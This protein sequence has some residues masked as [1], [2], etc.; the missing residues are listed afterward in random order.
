M[1]QTYIRDPS[2]GRYRY[3]SVL[4]VQFGVWN[5]DKHCLPGEQ[6][7]CKQLVW[8]IMNRSISLTFANSIDQ[9]APLVFAHLIRAHS[10]VITIIRDTRANP[11]ARHMAAN[12]MAFETGIKE[13][14]ASEPKSRRP[15]LCRFSGCILITVKSVA[16]VGRCGRRRRS[17]E[18]EFHDRI[19]SI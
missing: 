14:I 12:A 5:Y 2:Y 6:H 8:P 10:R 17:V 7:L 13:I 16:I 4:V 19:A 18:Y 11:P 9:S 3:R 15:S 1:V